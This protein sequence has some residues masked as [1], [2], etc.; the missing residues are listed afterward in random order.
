LNE[1]QSALDCCHERFK[2]QQFVEF[3]IVFE[4]TLPAG[5]LEVFLKFKDGEARLARF[6][7][8]LASID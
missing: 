1:I 7:P 4:Q 5:Q 2:F 8:R 6:T 3:L